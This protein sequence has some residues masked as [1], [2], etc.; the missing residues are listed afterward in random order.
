M[1]FTI[2]L[3]S[4]EISTFVETATHR[5]IENPGGA[6]TAVRVIGYRFL[7]TPTT[8]TVPIFVDIKCYNPHHN[9][10]RIVVTG[11]NGVA[12]DFICLSQT[13]A[14]FVMEVRNVKVMT[15]PGF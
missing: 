13:M 14:D 4:S 12:A 9:T 3:S 7:T 2:V 1:S 6:I 8:K 10:W 15:L 5:A 11:L